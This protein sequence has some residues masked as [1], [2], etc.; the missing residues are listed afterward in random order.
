MYFLFAFKA[1]RWASWN[2]L[3]CCLCYAY[4][5]L[6]VQS[7]LSERKKKTMLGTACDKSASGT[8]YAVML[9]EA[10]QSTLNFVLCNSWFWVNSFASRRS[11]GVERQGVAEPC[12]TQSVQMY[13]SACCFS[14]YSTKQFNCSCYQWLRH[15][16]IIDTIN[17]GDD[18]NLLY[19][20]LTPVLEVVSPLERL[21]F[22]FATPCTMC[23]R[24]RTFFFCHCCSQS[25]ILK[26]PLDRCHHS[27]LLCKYI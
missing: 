24:V 15:V 26:T 8:W 10:W 16:I 17:G 3:L 21:Q 9:I 20:C 11:H 2:C 1:P 5:C 27:T 6:L 4:E 23:V 12:D 19:K 13:C 22:S 25:R 7:C 18:S 14:C